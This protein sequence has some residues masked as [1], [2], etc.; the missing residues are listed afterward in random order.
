M[1]ICDKCNA[2]ILEGS[3]FCPQ[4]ADPVTEADVVA[5]PALK[6]KPAAVDISFGYSSSSNY[7][8]ALDL[9]RKLPTYTEIGEGKTISHSV[10]LSI[11]DVELVATIFD[12]VGS[13]KS[14]QMLIDGQ[15]ST[16][17]DLTY[18]GVGCYRKRQKALNPKQYCYGEDEY[19]YNI[20]GCQRMNMPLVYG[21]WL[22][23]GQFDKYGVWYFDKERIR[24]E[25]DESIH[26]NKLCPILNPDRIIETLEKLPDAVD[27]KTNK[28]WE[29][30]ISYEEV[31]GDYKKVAIGVDAVLKSAT[32]YIIED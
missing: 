13:W 29:Y 28:H 6:N 18:Y 3:K 12:L 30:R 7:S 19:C 23:Y 5:K 17:S 4:C 15:R 21:G 20:W 24:R 9:C 14:S 1:L 26:E 31:D 22:T 10:K 16:K 2:Q 27:P 32:Q 25:L 8:K 11:T